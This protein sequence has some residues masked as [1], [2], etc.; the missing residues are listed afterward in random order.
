MSSSAGE[1][2]DSLSSRFAALFTDDEKRLCLDLHAVGV[3]PAT[4]LLYLTFKDDKSE[5]ADGV[6]RDEE[7]GVA[8][9]PAEGVRRIASG[10]TESREEE[11]GNDVEFCGKAGGRRKAGRKK[12]GAAAAAATQQELPT[13][14]CGRS[15]AS[16]GS[17]SCCVQCP[18]RHTGCCRKREA[19]ESKARA[20]A[21]T[22]SGAPYTWCSCGRTVSQTAR[23]RH[24]TC[25][26]QCP[27]AH[28]DYCE[29]REQQRQAARPR[30]SSATT[31]A[32]VG[33]ANASRGA[34]TA[35]A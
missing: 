14:P 26:L 31:V 29:R 34:S 24:V 2:S 1:P 23:F 30:A 8:G 20:Q 33:G 12:A 25:C 32:T 10:R 3:S 5:I 22:N 35:D 19:R 16:D 4:C 18:K 11:G 21:G 28:T 7:A 15:I 13:C 9:V 6:K 17:G 27:N